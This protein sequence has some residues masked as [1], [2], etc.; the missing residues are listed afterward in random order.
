MCNCK[1]FVLKHDTPEIRRGAIVVS[2]CEGTRY[3]VVNLEEVA[4]Y[5]LTPSSYFSFHKDIVE[6]SRYWFEIVE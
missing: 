3:R 1:T 2:S 5:R 4:R 6:N